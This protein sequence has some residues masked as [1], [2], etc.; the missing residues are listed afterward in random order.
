MLLS[1]VLVH[2]ILGCLWELS[3]QTPM[4]KGD[5]LKRY[6]SFVDCFH[7]KVWE[8]IISS[9]SCPKGSSKHTHRH[10]LD[11]ITEIVV[12]T[13][14]ASCRIVLWALHYGQPWLG[15]TMS[16]IYKDTFSYCHPAYREKWLCIM[17]WDRSVWENS[18]LSSINSNSSM[19]WD[20]G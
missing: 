9:I 17:N 15:L 2:L 4:A 10:T 1:F 20:V 11:L 18:A 13:Y 16:L 14:L 12:D 8:H 6:F 5:I 7:L 19:L 3:K